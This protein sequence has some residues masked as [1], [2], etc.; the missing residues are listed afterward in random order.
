M[1][2]RDGARFSLAASLEPET[3]VV[4][5][6][7]VA[8]TIRSLAE[9]SSGIECLAAKGKT[10]SARSMRARGSKSSVVGLNGLVIGSV[11]L[12]LK[13]LLLGFER[14]EALCVETLI[15]KRRVSPAPNAVALCTFR[16]RCWR[17]APFVP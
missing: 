13:L 17:L 9:V 6:S 16:Q 10:G 5:N 11:T 7:S 15:K 2:S 4:R 1:K 8:A 14:G 3:I 12:G